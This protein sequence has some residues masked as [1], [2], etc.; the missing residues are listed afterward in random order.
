MKDKAIA[1]RKNKNLL[2][3]Y[4]M[5]DSYEKLIIYAIEHLLD[6][7]LNEKDGWT[8]EDIKKLERLEQGK[9]KVVFEE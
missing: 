2:R 6:L 4:N 5:N 3:R 8:Y 7:E 1:S 9:F